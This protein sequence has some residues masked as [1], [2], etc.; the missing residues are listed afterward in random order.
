MLAPQEGL[1]VAPVPPKAADL[2]RRP[3][4][5]SNLTKKSTQLAKYNYR[6]LAGGVE[7]V[8]V[9]HEKR[10]GCDKSISMR[11]LAHPRRWILNNS[12]LLRVQ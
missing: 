7:K 9:G 8:T 2:T 10:L 3:R 11:A 5:R 1:R 6:L 4:G 12:N